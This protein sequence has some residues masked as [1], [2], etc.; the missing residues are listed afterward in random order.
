[1]AMTLDFLVD[2]TIFSD[3]S[4][5]AILLAAGRGVSA[6]GGLTSAENPSFFPALSREFYKVV[7]PATNNGREADKSNNGIR[8]SVVGQA[9]RQR[10]TSPTTANYLSSRRLSA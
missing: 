3:L 6:R 8:I 2:A 9:I 5:V 10:R 7:G 1:M 4:R